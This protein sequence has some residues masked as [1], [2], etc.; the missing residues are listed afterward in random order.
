L[1]SHVAPT[2]GRV[3]VVEDDR[4][5]AHCIATALDCDGFEVQLAENGD[6]ALGVCSRW[7]PD[8]IVLDH[9]LPIMSGEAF[10]QEIR[11]QP[12]LSRVPVLL[13]SALD[14]L[15]A[16]ARRLRVAHWL[17]KPFDVDGLISALARMLGA[18]VPVRVSAIPAR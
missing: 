15:D 10:L 3:L 4:D 13:I 8:A 5:I 11:W 2:Q 6:D 9:N 1:D 14:D 16:I 17:A 12:G 7:L 18:N